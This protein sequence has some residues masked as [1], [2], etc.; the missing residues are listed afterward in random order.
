MTPSGDRFM[1]LMQV[2]SGLWVALII[3]G[4]VAPCIVDRLNGATRSQLEAVGIERIE[5]CHNVHSNW[6]EIVWIEKEAE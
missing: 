5:R 1:T 6:Y 3:L 4:I 2:L